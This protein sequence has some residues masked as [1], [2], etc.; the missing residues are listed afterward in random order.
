MTRRIRHA[1]ARLAV[2]ALAATTGMIVSASPA[3]A[4]GQETFG[5]RV[6]PGVVLTWNNPC[7]NNR[8]AS[9]YNAGFKVNNL[10]GSG[11]TFSW[12]YSG[13][14][15]RVVA[16]CTATSSDC[17]LAVA[18]SDAVISVTVTYSQGGLSATRSANAIIRQYCGNVLC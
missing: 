8:P 14:V 17:G 18:N 10:S 9:T 16:G 11:Y 12:S 5:C 7:S 2:C 4:F 3:Q 1:I 15:L 6:S 13:P